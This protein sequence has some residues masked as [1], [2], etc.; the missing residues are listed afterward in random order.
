[1]GEWE[2]RERRGIKEIE[3]K[4]K[5]NKNA[6]KKVKKNNHR[7]FSFRW[8]YMNTE[9]STLNTYVLSEFFNTLI[10]ACLVHM[11]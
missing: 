11:N 5:K 4:E 1:M 2:G 3:K 8:D 7:K 9:F 6:K 10:S